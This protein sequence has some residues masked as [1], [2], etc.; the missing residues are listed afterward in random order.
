MRLPR[1]SPPSRS[2][3][4]S[5]PCC[6][7]AT[8][9]D[10]ARH[11]R[12]APPP[13][14]VALPSRRR[15]DREP[16]TPTGS[17]SPPPRRSRPSTGSWSAPRRS[18]PATACT[19][20]PAPSPRSSPARWSIRTSR[21]RSATTARRRSWAGPRNSGCSSGQV[22]FTG[23]GA[24]PGGVTGIV[25][26]TVDGSRI[27]FRGI[28]D[29]N[30]G[31]EPGSPAAF[32]EFWRRVSSLPQDARRRARA[33]AAL[34]ARWLRDPRR[35]AAPAGGRNSPATSRTGRWTWRSASSGWRSPTAIAAAPSTAR[36]PRRSRPRWAP[37]TSSRSGPRIR[38]PARRSG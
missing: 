15:V 14:V 24:L 10:R 3:R 16:A 35:P 27:T 2:P 18:S 8:P 28:P 19:S 4:W 37:R 23:D 25:E 26:L 5:S 38:R 30:E 20:C 7:A 1:P 32:A 6:G 31:G 22:D 11:G 36:T 21:A 13:P 29:S 12:A 9:L 34:D 17:A 33:G